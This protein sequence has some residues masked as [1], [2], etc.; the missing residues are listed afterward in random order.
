MGFVAWLNRL[1][2]LVLGTFKQFGRGS[3]WLILLLWAIVGWLLLLAHYKFYSPIFYGFINAW[4]SIFPAE[5]GIGFYHYP[6]HFILLP[7][8]FGWAKLAVGLV[9]EG[10]VLGGAALMFYRGYAARDERLDIEP[11]ELS[12]AASVLRPWIQL[13]L[14]WIALNGLVVLFTLVVPDLLK[15]MLMYSPRRQMLFDYAVLP[16]AYTLFLAL[17]FFVIPS[18]VVNGE[19]IL[20]ALKRSFSIFF[21]NPFTCLVLALVVMFIPVVIAKVADNPAL[22]VTKF[23]PEL[24]Y[25]LL[26]AGLLVDMVA[27]FFWM[28]LAV[29]FLVYEE[30]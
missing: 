1:I 12:L 19:N 20:A 10:V 16:G 28:G 23:H 17:F 7:Y 26:L 8:F 15:P 5:S 29:R 4:V 3:V 2:D 27:N 24:V 21:R 18:I 6:G 25:W 30:E 22:I 14:A 11:S 9:A 13:V